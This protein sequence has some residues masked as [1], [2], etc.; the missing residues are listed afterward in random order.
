MLKQLTLLL[1]LISS[2]ALAET[3]I[4]GNVASKCII[5]TDKPGVY[6]NPTASKL[7][8]KPADGGVLPVIRYDVILGDAYIAKI[9]TP[10]SFSTSPSLNDVLNWEGT[11]IVGQVS[12]P[13]MAAYDT[14]K[15]IYDNVTEFDLSIAGSTWFEVD[16]SV[17]YGYDKA[18]PGGTYRSII[19]AECIA[20]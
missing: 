10:Q 19:Q 5:Q 7:S 3:E 11:V 16:S 1:L 9:T 8:T 17:N 4:T 20:K 18:L 2:S 13:G 14:S 15:V 6:G 12:D